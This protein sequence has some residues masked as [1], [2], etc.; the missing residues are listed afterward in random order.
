MSLDSQLKEKLLHAD[1]EATML[2]GPHERVRVVIAGGSAL[3][4][5]SVLSRPTP[6]IDVLHVHPLLETIF[7]KYDMNSRMTAYTDMMPYNFEDRLK[8]VDLKT[9]TLDYWTLSLE[10][11][12]LMKLNSDRDKDQEDIS[13]KAVLSEINWEK[14]IDI[15]QSGE[16]D[17]SFNERRYKEFLRRFQN[18]LE[19]YKPR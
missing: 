19:Q 1:Q 13:N 8:R 16:M 5:L 4:L 9:K 6:D 15:V 12:V 3:L 17:V 7:R 11:L 10:D 2:L 18:Y 14:I